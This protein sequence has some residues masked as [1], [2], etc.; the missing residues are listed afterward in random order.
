MARLD[1]NLI[2]GHHVLPGAAGNLGI[3]GGQ[4]RPGDL[5]VESALPQRLI[6]CEHDLGGFLPPGG[7][8]TGAFAGE[9]VKA[10]KLRAA[11]AP[12]D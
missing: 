7:G 3:G 1:L 12:A 9:R 5:E 8:Q 2:F 6:F 10:V 11:F 4:I